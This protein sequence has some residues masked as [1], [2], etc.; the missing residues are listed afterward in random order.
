MKHLKRALLFC[1]ALAL[2]VSAV[3][4]PL[5]T[6]V[7]ATGYTASQT[8]SWS[9]NVSANSIH[10][11]TSTPEL[12]QDLIEELRAQN[13]TPAIKEQDEALVASVEDATNM[14]YETVKNTIATYLKD[15]LS[16][17]TINVSDL[18][19]DKNT[20]V[21]VLNEVLH[22]NY[23]YLSMVTQGGEVTKIN[24]SVS[25]GFAAAMDAMNSEYA[26]VEVNADTQVAQDAAVSLI[27]TPAVMAMTREVSCTNHTVAADF[28]GDFNADGE[29]DMFDL[30]VLRDMILD[31]ETDWHQDFNEDGEVDMFDIFDLRDGILNDDLPTGEPIVNFTWAV[32]PDYSP[33]FRMDAEGNML[34]ADGNITEDPAQAIMNG[35]LLYNPEDKSISEGTLP[36]IYHKLTEVSFKCDVCGEDIVLT[37]DPETEEDELASLSMAQDI[38]INLNTYETVACNVGETPVLAEGETMEDYLHY[39]EMQIGTYTDDT[40]SIMINPE[41]GEPV[42]DANGNYIPNMEMDE[43][44][45]V[46]IRGVRAEDIAVEDGTVI[47]LGGVTL[48]VLHT[49]GHTPGSICLLD[50]ANKVL[51]SGDTVS[52][53]PVFLFGETRDPKAYG[54]TLRKLQAMAAEGIFDT[55]YCCHNTC[56]VDVGVIDELI[57]ALEGALNGSIEG[58]E[59][60]LGFGPVEGLKT[61]SFGRSGI[62]MCL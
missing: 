8:S 45:N 23:L 40:F 53:G 48:E 47:E 28:I 46:V 29:I 2:V 34:D 30:F 22:E 17:G 43:E 6:T 42:L 18:G 38:Y 49:P 3:A 26:E 32:T 36:N 62:H 12:I 57:A 44:G 52:Y 60:K 54:E 9:G 21:Q 56:P 61:Y 58:V 10:P 14:T 31:D 19:L 11:F 20:M 41:T 39:T 51:Y 5:A 7:H 55:V 33:V 13:I 50:R 35:G 15:N 24:F 1:M 37:D 16:D 25:Q 59:A 4:A 27:S